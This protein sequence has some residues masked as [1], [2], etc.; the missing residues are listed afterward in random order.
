ML[1]GSPL[2]NLGLTPIL[3]VVV[4]VDVDGNDVIRTLEPKGIDPGSI[5]GRL[6]PPD[7]ACIGGVP[8]IHDLTDPSKYAYLLVDGGGGDGDDDDDACDFFDLLDGG[9][10]DDGD[11]YTDLRLFF[12]NK[13]IKSFP[14]DPYFPELCVNGLFSEDVRGEFDENRFEAFTPVEFDNDDCGLGAELALIL[15]PL[16]WLHRRRRRAA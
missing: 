12:K 1:C 13:E 16:L 15:P 3:D 8:P 14:F 7:E 4:G 9:E 5:L 10:G 2:L 6:V 11:A